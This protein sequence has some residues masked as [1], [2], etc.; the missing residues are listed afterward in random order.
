VKVDRLSGLGFE[1]L[2]ELDTVLEKLHHV[3]AWVELRAEPCRM[4]CRPA[5]QLVFLN[6]DGVAEPE[7]CQVVE[8]TA[9]ANAAADDDD[10]RF[11]LHNPHLKILIAP[12][13]RVSIH[14]DR[15]RQIDGPQTLFDTVSEH[16]GYLEV[17]NAHTAWRDLR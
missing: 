11:T 12:S 2:I 7:L 8:Q 3:K 5:S 17:H 14:A 15:R 4:P 16:L 1:R 10:F 13:A 6:Q 9:T